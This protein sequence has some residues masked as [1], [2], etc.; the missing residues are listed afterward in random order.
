MLGHHRHASE[1]PLKWRFAGGPMIT[2]LY[3][4]LDPPF[5]HKLNK[6]VSLRKQIRISR[7]TFF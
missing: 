4:H 1:T 2:S 6:V 7:M 5:R 3:C